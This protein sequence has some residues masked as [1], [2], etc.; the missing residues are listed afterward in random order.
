MATKARHERAR[1]A[2]EL[3]NV[4]TFIVVMCSTVELGALHHQDFVVGSTIGLG[5]SSEVHCVRELRSV[6]AKKSI[7]II[8][9][10]PRFEF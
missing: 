8:S 2:D 7:I 4:N 9:N 5:S 3:W 1:G 6:R 10:A